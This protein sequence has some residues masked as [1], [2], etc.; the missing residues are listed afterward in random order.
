MA[1]ILGLSS[2]PEHYVLLSRCKQVHIFPRTTNFIKTTNEGYWLEE[3][4]ARDG[5]DRTFYLWLEK[6]QICVSTDPFQGVLDISCHSRYTWEVYL[7]VFGSD[8]QIIL[9]SADHCT[10]FLS[11]SLF[12][13]EATSWYLRP[14]VLISTTAIFQWAALGKIHSTLEEE[15]RLKL[16]CSSILFTFQNLAKTEG[17][18]AVMSRCIW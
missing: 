18:N 8:T 2:N 4:F 17:R 15:R 1:S 10:L 6:S 14:V 7:Q 12:P 16:C 11:S 3:L 9:L 13:R 5:P